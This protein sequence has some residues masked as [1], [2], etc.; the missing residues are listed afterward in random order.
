M[1]SELQ[2]E[3]RRVGL[4]QRSKTFAY[5]QGLLVVVCR[6]RKLLSSYISE[7][8]RA[9]PESEVRQDNLNLKT[10]AKLPTNSDPPII[11]LCCKPNGEYFILKEKIG[12]FKLK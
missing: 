8:G 6:L 4:R 1:L 5:L 3:A 7:S 2:I 12:Y 11:A 10:L 9:F